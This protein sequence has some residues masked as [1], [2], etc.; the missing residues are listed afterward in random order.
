MIVVVALGMAREV[1]LASQQQYGD[2]PLKRI[3]RHGGP[4]SPIAAVLL[5]LNA[6]YR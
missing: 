5:T 2:M 6:P 4:A 1:L 3:A